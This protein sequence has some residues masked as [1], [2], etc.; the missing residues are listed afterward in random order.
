MEKW[1]IEA[2]PTEKDPCRY[3]LL[4]K[5]VLKDILGVIREFG[6]KCKR[7]RRTDS[8]EGFNY[9]L[10]ISYLD[11]EELR[12]LTGMLTELAPGRGPK[13]S[14]PAS[15][16]EPQAP[17]Q[18]PAVEPPVAHVFPDGAGDAR[19]PVLTAPPAPTAV[20]PAA[21]SPAPFGL[22]P[23]E[24]PAP[25][26][27]VPVAQAPAQP[28]PPANA[29]PEGGRDLALQ[30]PGRP[31][32]P[33]SPA[34]PLAPFAN[35]PPATIF[36]RPA[37][38]PAPTLMPPTSEPPATIFVRPADLP[39]QPAAPGPAPL[40]PAPIVIPPPQ[41]KPLVVGPGI[42]QLP[43][44]QPTE[45]PEPVRTT[46][47][48]LPAGPEPFLP[49]PEL[50]ALVNQPPPAAPPAPRAVP[51]AP[52]PP[53]LGD[54]M[55]PPP[56]P[57][58]TVGRAPMPP[59]P[60]LPQP[61]TQPAEPGAPE[62]GAQAPGALAPAV[63]LTRSAK[64]TKPLW[65]LGM[66]SDDRIDLNSIQVGPYNRFSH[67]AA[68]SVVGAPG[69]MYNPLFIF[70]PAGVG[71][72]HMIKAIGAELEK[73]L[74][75]GALLTSGSQLA[76]AVSRSLEEGKFPELERTFAESKALLVD[77][78]HLL[79]VTDENKAS[80]AKVFALFFSRSLQVVL[81]SFYPA[82]SLGALEESLKISLRK[83]W[84]VDMKLATGDAQKDM[85]LGAFSR[86]RVDLTNDEAGLFLTKLGKNYAELLKWTR[87]MITLRNL[88]EAQELPSN[89][90][91]LMTAMFPGDPAED[92]QDIPTV[93]EIDAARRFAPPA[94][95]PGAGNLAFVLPKGGEGMAPWVTQQ[96]YG[97]A[98]KNRIAASYKHALFGSYDADQPLGVPF[99]I[100]EMCRKA[101]ADAALIV[102]PP[103]TSKLTGR[104]GEFSHAVG[105]ILEGLDIPMGWLPFDGM[106]VPVNYLR[107]HLDL[108]TRTE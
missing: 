13:E 22:T 101:G 74:Q 80:L 3:A 103:S 91:R 73:A 5:G 105:H 37:E 16:P 55:A 95:G 85:V 2:V 53:G 24:A 33:A 66:A 99:Q 72:T 61:G 81:T 26:A 90:D 29:F 18:P 20:Q 35:E 45:A 31:G 102:G 6:T 76:N 48:D 32:P 25:V 49:G 88:L 64:T 78:L 19:P 77:D 41:T 82:R 94:S 43:L 4:F 12:K 7:P 52:P 1:A 107:I 79:N 56:P 65:G 42:E 63:S 17:Q 58:P 14:G 38:L 98:A 106:K 62:P 57:V 68:A 47:V 28:S 69:N 50:P 10:I 11:E 100:G 36:V 92:A 59:T 40:E 9:Q 60:G 83:G 108:M 104:I 97:V 21:P 70:G 86:L 67:A 89:F 44:T 46:R 93:A 71:K 54:F 51:G 96:F 27:P 87:R 39:A 84:S 75:G 8:S 23:V 15:A 34:S 30:Y